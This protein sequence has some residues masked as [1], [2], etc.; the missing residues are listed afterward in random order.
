MFPFHLHIGNI[1]FPYYEGFYFAATIFFGIVWA[2]KKL[3]R[4]GFPEDESYKLIMLSIIGALVGARLFHVVFWGSGYYLDNP[5][6]IL[7]VWEGGVSITGGIAGALATAYI[8]SKTIKYSFIDYLATLSP[9][10][11]VSQGIGRIG[12]FFNGDAFGVPTRLPWGV[13]FPRFGTD[14]FSFRLNTD[15]SS[16]AWNWCYSNG[17]VSGDSI[18]TVPLHP[19]QIYET[20]FDIVLALVILMFLKNANNKKMVC[21]VYIIGYSLFRFFVEYI[22]GDREQI[23]MWNTSFIQYMLLGFVAVMVIIAFLDYRLKKV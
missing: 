7:K 5:I 17:F 2:T 9:I 21:Y 11:L 18:K 4:E 22:R 19:T 16:A 6:L 23:L 1:F 3:K 15:V 12:C 14:I 8:V 20:I 13:V 10:I